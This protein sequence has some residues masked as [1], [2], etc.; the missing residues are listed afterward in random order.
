MCGKEA[1]YT[2]EAVIADTVRHFEV[3]NGGAHL[4]WAQDLIISNS[5]D[6]TAQMTIKRYR[7]HRPSAKDTTLRYAVSIEMD[8]AAWAH[9]YNV[10]VEKVHK[11]VGDYLKHNLLGS[12]ASENE[13]WRN[14]DVK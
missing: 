9:E 12:Q 6:H 4:K 10:P 13:L 8:Q 3:C 2:I 11:D 14:V 1:N 5:P 7:P